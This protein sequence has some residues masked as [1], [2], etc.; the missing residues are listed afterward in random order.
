VSFDRERYEREVLEPAR[1]AGNEPPRDLAARYALSPELL[2]S[3]AGFAQQVSEMTMFWNALKQQ[4]KYQRLAEALLAAHAQ[5]G[6][7]GLHAARVEEER[8]LAQAQLARWVTDLATATS[9]VGSDTLQRLMRESGFGPAVVRAALLERGVRVVEQVEL[10]GPPTSKYHDLV[11]HL[12]VLGCRL[13]AEVVFEDL[14]RHGFRVLDGFALADTGERLQGPGPDGPLRRR[15]RRVELARPDE[16]RNAAAKVLVILLELEEQ[17]GALDALLLWEVAQVLREVPI[18]SLSQRA[19]A[20]E[21][22]ELGLESEEADVLALS[23]IEAGRAAPNRAN[24][25]ELSQA[26][27]EGRLRD[28][29]RL[30]A[31]LADGDLAPLRETVAAVERRVAEL[32]DR[33]A[34]ARGRGDHEEAAALLAEALRDAADDEDLAKRLQAIPPPPPGGVVQGVEGGRVTVGWR[35]SPVRVGAVRYRVARGLRRWPR[36]VEDG[37]EVGSTEGNQLVDIGPPPGQPVFHG[38]FA[39]RDG[40]LWSAPAWAGPVV[41]TP[42]VAGFRLTADHRSVTGSWEPPPGAAQVEVV[43]LEQGRRPSRR[44]GTPVPGAGLLG[45]TDR[46]VEQDRTYSYRVSVVYLDQDGSRHRSPGLVASITAEAPVEAVTDLGVEVLLPPPSHPTRPTGLA[47]APGSRGRVGVGGIGL[48]LVATWTPPRQGTVR[49]RVSSQHPSPGAG[50]QAGPGRLAALGDELPGEP[51]RLPDG[52]VRLAVPAGDLR[53]RCQLTP[54]TL[55]RSRVVVG[56]AVE[57]SVAG[58]VT[59]P[60]ARRF[61]EVVRLSWV[62]PAESTLVRIRWRLASSRLPGEGEGRALC[63]RRHYEDHGGFEAVVGREAACFF[64]EAIVQEAGREI[65]APAVEVRVGGLG[66][67][68]RYGIRR[69]GFPGRGRTL[70]L[71]VERPCD[72]PALVLVRRPGTLPPLRAEQGTTVVRVPAQRLDPSAPLAVPLELPSGRAR[73]RLFAEAAG[74]V[75]LVHPPAGE[76]DVGG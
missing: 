42:E 8:R 23:V 1:L 35:P 40:Q 6:R 2:A 57:V 56:E 25:F 30:A 5:L 62:W 28:A 33:A 72:V 31:R 64:L 61:A 4:R 70:L 21:A 63:S 22:R 53:G 18:T 7:D 48:T 75:E 73:L 65:A 46:E 11:T 32:S 29:R 20:R 38:V 36:T 54:V 26:L 60:V 44:D 17:P 76:L 66:C 45:F 51:E 47:G 41:V 49:I 16:R 71:E 27:G 9:C 74:D 15:L 10:R 19:L 50:E 59:D 24:E 69:A 55:G 37:A 14:A 68:V 12:R 13:S 3:P 52:R 39:T 58:P 43:R 67:A 34:Q